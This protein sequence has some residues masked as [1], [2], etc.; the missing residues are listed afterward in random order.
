M[1]DCLTLNSYSMK[2]NF[3][4]RRRSNRYAFSISQNLD[5]KI[6][7]QVLALKDKMVYLSPNL[8]QQLTSKSLNC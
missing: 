8:N 2:K 5:Y 6:L 3:K 1:F 7:K 4:K